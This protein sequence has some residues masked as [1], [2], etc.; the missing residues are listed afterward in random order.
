MIN[1]GV[2]YGFA[3]WYL[4]LILSVITGVGYVYVSMYWLGS[5]PRGY[6]VIVAIA[7]LVC[8]AY[9]RKNNRLSTIFVCLIIADI[10]FSVLL[11]GKNERAEYFWE[12][13]FSILPNVDLLIYCVEYIFEILKIEKMAHSF[14]NFLNPF[15]IVLLCCVFEPHKDSGNK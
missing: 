11:T 2:Y 4:M 5:I 3:L 6:A 8:A 12:S 7:V 15:I 9:I 13:V 14:H 10:F 1:R